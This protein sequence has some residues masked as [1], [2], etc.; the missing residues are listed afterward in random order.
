MREGNNF[1]TPNT[2]VLFNG[3]GTIYHGE[4]EGRGRKGYTDAFSS[5]TTVLFVLCWRR[6]ISPPL[7]LKMMWPP[8]LPPRDKCWQADRFQFLTRVV[9]TFSSHSRS[10]SM[11]FGCYALYIFREEPGYVQT[12][13][14]GF[15]RCSMLPACPPIR[16]KSEKRHLV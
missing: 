1:S 13:A 6:L 14:V 3:L 16:T 12:I 5:F 8:P 7:P 10:F 9:N 15:Q 11:D 2:H 4:G